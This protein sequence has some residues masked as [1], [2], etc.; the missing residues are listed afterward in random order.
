MEYSV[1][2]RDDQSIVERAQFRY[3]GDAISFI[4]LR[5]SNEVQNC[6]WYVRRIDTGF[7]VARWRYVPSSGDVVKEI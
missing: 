4:K 2:R 3:V 7:V 6:Y 1:S 5:I